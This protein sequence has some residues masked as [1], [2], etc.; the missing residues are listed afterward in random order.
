MTQTI[1]YPSK[2][3]TKKHSLRPDASGDSL[4]FRVR[5]KIVLDKLLMNEVL[6]PK[7]YEI[8]HDFIDD[9][10]RCE[11]GMYKTSNMN[12]RVDGGTMDYEDKNYDTRMS[13]DKTLSEAYKVGEDQKTILLKIINDK[14]LNETEIKIVRENFFGVVDAISRNRVS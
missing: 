3:F 12:E 6:P 10:E 4:R 9:I 11:R 2:H 13:V 14:E 7:H 1:K 5:D 8:I